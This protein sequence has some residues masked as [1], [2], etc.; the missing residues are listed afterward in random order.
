M[1]IAIRI[2]WQ[3]AQSSGLIGSVRSHGA[4][5]RCT[6][7][8]RRSAHGHPD[9][10]CAQSSSVAV[11]AVRCLRVEAATCSNRMRGGRPHHVRAAQRSVA[12]LSTQ[13]Q[14]PAARAQPS[15]PPHIQAPGHRSAIGHCVCVCYARVMTKLHVKE[16]IAV[17]AWHAHPGTRAPL[18]KGQSDPATEAGSRHSCQPTVKLHILPLVWSFP[19]GEG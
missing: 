7:I 18:R 13:A 2:D 14:T 11:C 12:Q 1:C 19:L 3:C 10:R 4:R 15:Q 17:L 6:V 8:Q 5:Q 9:W 16:G